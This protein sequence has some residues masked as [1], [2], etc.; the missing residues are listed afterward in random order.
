MYESRRKT[1]LTMTSIHAEKVS[2]PSA[3][4][5][6]GMGSTT[7]T[8]SGLCSSSSPLEAESES[9][10]VLDVVVAIIVDLV[11]GPMS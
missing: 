8:T 9:K 1:R 10:S 7:T 2:C 4:S 3:G 6:L 11:S 5:G